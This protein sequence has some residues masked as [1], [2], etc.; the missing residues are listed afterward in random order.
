MS[1][2]TSTN[3][4]SLSIEQICASVKR[5]GYGARQYVRLYGEEFEVVSDPFPAS[6]GIAVSVKTKKGDQVRVIQIPA[7]VLQSVKKA[8]AA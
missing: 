1:I 3:L 4:E 8:T 5:L 7:T 6:G 2:M